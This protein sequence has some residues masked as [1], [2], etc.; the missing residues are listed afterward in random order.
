MGLMNSTDMS[1]DS[2]G[3]QSYTS[4]SSNSLELP[5]TSYSST[6]SPRN[7][8]P[9]SLSTISSGNHSQYNSIASTST[10]NDLTASMYDLSTS[11]RRA[12]GCEKVLC[13]F[14]LLL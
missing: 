14:F 7:N 13:L 10:I 3:Y 6:N 11:D 8:S 12:P 4:S 2:S 5:N 1:Q 9:G